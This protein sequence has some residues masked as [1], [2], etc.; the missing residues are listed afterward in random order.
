MVSEVT[1]MQDLSHSNL[2]PLVGVCLDMAQ[3]PSIVMPYMANGSL[4]D[5]LKKEREKPA[6]GFRC[7]HG[8]HSSCA[9]VSLANVPPNL[10]GHVLLGPAE[11]CAQRSGG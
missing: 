10:S 7:R 3:G 6:L 1:K 9:Q 5:Y 8:R 2:M 11:G 4:L